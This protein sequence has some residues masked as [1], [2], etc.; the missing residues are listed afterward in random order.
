MADAGEIRVIYRKNGIISRSDFPPPH[1]D[2]A[3][4]W[5]QFHRETAL[6]SALCGDDLSSGAAERL[7]DQIARI[8]ECG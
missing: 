6:P 5:V 8:R 1:G 3:I 4:D 7:I 2:V